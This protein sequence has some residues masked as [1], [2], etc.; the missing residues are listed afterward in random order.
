MLE[1]K[2]KAPETTH[3]FIL[4]NAKMDGKPGEKDNPKIIS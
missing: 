2:V 4:L 1:I 3:I